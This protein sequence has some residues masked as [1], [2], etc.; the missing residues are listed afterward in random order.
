MSDRLA[1]DRQLVAGGAAKLEI[2]SKPLQSRPW[3]NPAMAS[4][5]ARMSPG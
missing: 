4:A 5:A 1:D 2:G 3:M